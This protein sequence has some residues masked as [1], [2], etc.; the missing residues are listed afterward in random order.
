MTK[1]QFF[2]KLREILTAM[3]KDYRRFHD[4]CLTYDVTPEDLSSVF[5]GKER[6]DQHFVKAI[7][8]GRA[9][10]PNEDPLIHYW[11]THGECNV[12]ALALCQIIKHVFGIHTTY[13]GFDRDNK[14]HAAVMFEYEGV[15][16]FADGLM[17]SSDPRDLY[18][19]DP[20]YRVIDVGDL[21][22]HFY[23]CD[24]AAYFM[25]IIWYRRFGVEV[26]Q[27]FEGW[28]NPVML[29]SHHR[30]EFYHKLLKAY[31]DIAPKQETVDVK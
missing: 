3:A 17:Y 31:E 28:E 29:P 22:K 19:G 23:A 10:I 24:P 1:D 12:V 18:R 15:C 27:A 5:G 16:Y 20:A 25:T 2:E 13:V 21:K 6:V 14:W 30:L 11:W 8:E 26:T 4:T 9:L 7:I